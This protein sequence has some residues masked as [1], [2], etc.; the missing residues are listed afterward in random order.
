[1]PRVRYEHFAFVSQHHCDLLEKAVLVGGPLDGQELT[2][3]SGF[4]GIGCR[5]V[6]TGQEEWGQELYYRR[7]EEIDPDG[8]IVC[9]FTGGPPPS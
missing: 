4:T 2:P 3:S 7:T 1:M 6:E 8:C 5:R 9:R